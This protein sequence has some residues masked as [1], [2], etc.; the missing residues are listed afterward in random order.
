M[1]NDREQM[2]IEMARWA[3]EAEAASLR[4]A[5]AQQRGEAFK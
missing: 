3:R 1:F 5:Q 2:L 4:K